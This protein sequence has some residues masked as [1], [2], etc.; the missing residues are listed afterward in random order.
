MNRLRRIQGRAG[1][2]GSGRPDADI[3]SGS[4][5]IIGL[6][7]MAFV[8][9]AFFVDVSRSLNAHGASFDIASQAARA[10]ADEVTQGSLRTGDPS[11][12]RIDPAAARAAGQ[13]WL[14]RA[15]ASGKVSV[16]QDDT[17]VT[18]TARVTCKA[19]LLAAFGYKDL[20]RSA[21]ASATLLYGTAGGIGRPIA[22]QQVPGPA[23][24]G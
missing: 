8:L 22:A 24:G 6:V 4:I 18:V 12:L 11:R 17:V 13:A 10:A 20:S 3:G 14:T 19:T 23:A 16:S 2:A 1:F 21:T 5:F 15:G 7:A 9:T